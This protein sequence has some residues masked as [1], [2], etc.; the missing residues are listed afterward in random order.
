[1]D[2]LS[3]DELLCTNSGFIIIPVLPAILTKKIV[4]TF[5]TA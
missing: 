5:T 4:F 3:K 1:M 2:E